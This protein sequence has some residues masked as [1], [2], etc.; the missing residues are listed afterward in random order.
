MELELMEL[1]SEELKKLM[2][3]ITHLNPLF[4]PEN[5]EAVK[6]KD[7]TVY[8]QELPMPEG[9]DEDETISLAPY[10][11]IQSYSSSGG[12]NDRSIPITFVIG[13]YDNNPKRNGV[14]DCLR[15]KERIIR[16]FAEEPLIGKFEAAEDWNWELL[17]EDTHPFYFGGLKMTFT[18]PPYKRINK[19]I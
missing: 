11:L 18:A 8:M 6:Y 15:I 1:L 7:L 13:V 10:I 2:W 14:L 12:G 5:G 19:F 3:D 4:D 9:A 17:D 16:R